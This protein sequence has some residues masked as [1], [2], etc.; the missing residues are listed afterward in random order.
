MLR[1]ILDAEAG[2]RPTGLELLE[3][4]FNSSSFYDLSSNSLCNSLPDR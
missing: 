2:A 1:D 4:E 3:I